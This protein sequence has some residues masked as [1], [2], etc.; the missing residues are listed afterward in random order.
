MEYYISDFHDKVVRVDIE[1]EVAFA[2]GKGENESRIGN[3]T[4]IVTDAIIANDHITKEEYE[5]Y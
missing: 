1:N 5:S 2:K 4:K 3:D